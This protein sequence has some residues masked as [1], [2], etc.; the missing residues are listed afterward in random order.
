MKLVKFSLLICIAAFATG[1]PQ[2]PDKSFPGDI[3]PGSHLPKR[4]QPAGETHDA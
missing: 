1:C 3:N 4:G 2:G